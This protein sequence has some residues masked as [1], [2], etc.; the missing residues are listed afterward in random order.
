M[1]KPDLALSLLVSAGIVSDAAK[2]LTKEDVVAYSHLLL[3]YGIMEKAYT[4]HKKK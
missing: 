2:D 3:A 4:F 1:D